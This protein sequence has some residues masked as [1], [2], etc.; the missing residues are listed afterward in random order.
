[1][2]AFVT[3]KYESES[4]EIHPIRLNPVSVTPAGTAPAGAVTSSISAKVSRSRR[5]FG[6][7]P[8]GI[9][10][11]LT[12]GAAPDTFKRTAFIP[13]LL[14]SAWNTGNNVKGGTVSYKGGSWTVTSLS[15][16]YIG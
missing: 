10:V 2:A 4:G 9:N 11:S 7:R 16:E 8:R 3:T 13:I 14:A 5:E 1:M 12:V 15:P 6:L